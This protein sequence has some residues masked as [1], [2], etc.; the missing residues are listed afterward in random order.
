VTLAFCLRRKERA[1]GT[2]SLYASNVYRV[3]AD[4]KLIGYGPE[5]TAVGYSRERSIDIG[6]AR[7]IVV[8][9]AGYNIS[10]YANA[11]ER[12][13][14]AA[15]IVCG[16][17]VVASTEDFGCRFIDDR[18]RRVQRLSF[19]RNFVE[20][21]C[22]RSDKSR[23]Y[24]GEFG[25]YPA[26]ETE[27]VCA[28]ICLEGNID[29]VS[30]DEIALSL[31]GEG[32]AAR[33]ENMPCPPKYIWWEDFAECDKMDG[34]KAAELD[35]DLVRELSNVDFSR[36]GE[37]HYRV[38]EAKTAVTG[39]INLHVKAGSDCTVYAVFDEIAEDKAGVPLP[40]F[41]RPVFHN[42]AAWRLAA[43]EYGLLTFEPYEFKYLSVICDGEAE[44][45]SVGLIEIAN[46]E[47]CAEFKCTDEKIKKVFNAGKNS[48]RQNATDI[49]MDCPGRE[50]A[51]W[52]C[53]AYF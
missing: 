31:S 23:F 1:S 37:L 18:L 4:G 47:A 43:G 12:P 33:G 30:Y 20:Y 22:M 17:R 36:R 14:F 34:Y 50:R 3:F 35:A 7:D 16:G 41:S 32:S 29:N 8:E 27:E 26:A 10:C 44:T 2:L 38:F 52:L 21:Y 51:G 6:S 49:F 39:L 24:C 53:D 25:L 19:Q 11:L 28:P 42:A 46:R 9:V 45:E 40:E 13:F 15:E 5:R 48:F